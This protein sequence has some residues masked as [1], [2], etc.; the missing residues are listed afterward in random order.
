MTSCVCLTAHTITDTY[1]TLHTWS[2]LQLDASR[3]T[4]AQMNSRWGFAFREICARRIASATNDAV[5]RIQSRKT[6]RA[7][8]THTRNA[9]RTH[10]ERSRAQRDRIVQAVVYS[11]LH[12]ISNNNRISVKYAIVVFSVISWPTESVRV[13]QAMVAIA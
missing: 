13:G 12:H 6:R 9:K 2:D 1:Y 11:E 7:G 4:C 3:A 10:S 8:N 5:V